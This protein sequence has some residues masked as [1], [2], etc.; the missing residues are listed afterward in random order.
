LYRHYSFRGKSS[1]GKKERN[2]A[3]TKSEAQKEQNSEAQQE[4]NVTREQS[5]REKLYRW[6]HIHGECLIFSLAGD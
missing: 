1:E 5:W 3:G 2:P 4:Q 6:K